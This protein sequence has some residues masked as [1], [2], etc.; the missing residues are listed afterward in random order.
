M[1]TFD[2]STKIVPECRYTYG[3]WALLNHNGITDVLYITRLCINGSLVARRPLEIATGYQNFQLVAQIGYW[4][5]K[6]YTFLLLSVL[7]F[8]DPKG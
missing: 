8:Y 2:L 3:C 5:I 1:H 6:L 4:K 7:L